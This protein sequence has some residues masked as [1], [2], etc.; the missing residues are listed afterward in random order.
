MIRKLFA[1][2]AFVLILGANQASA[3]CWDNTD[4]LIVKLKRLNLS[5]EQL[6]DVFQYQE[7]HR[8]LITSSHQD[9]SGCRHHEA[10]E[11][12]FQKHSIGVLTNE[13]FE[14]L[15]GRERNETEGLRYDNYLL[16]KE[17]A[18][19]KKELQALK[20]EMKALAG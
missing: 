6:K 7:Q 16:K 18:R 4:E 2:A 15:Q 8:D 17:V 12:N 1:V 5:T 11:V 3:F 19:L 14:K 10:M 20:V 13:Q 9:G